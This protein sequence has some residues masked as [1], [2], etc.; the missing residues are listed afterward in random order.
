M[1]NIALNSL[2]SQRRSLARPA[3]AAAAVLALVG[4]GL[5]QVGWGEVLDARGSAS[6]P[7]AGMLLF[8][9]SCYLVVSGWFYL[10]GALW[11][12][13][14]GQPWWPRRLGLF[15]DGMLSGVVLAI[16]IRGHQSGVLGL[17]L[18]TIPPVLFAFCGVS[19]MLT[20][21]TWH[22]RSDEREGMA[23][24]VPYVRFGAAVLLLVNLMIVE[25]GGWSRSTF[26]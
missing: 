1:D 4:V 26:H 12:K 15:C 3:H 11:A 7:S 16:M 18:W 20:F 2:V 22:K 10:L 5:V 24:L 8:L 13:Y 9:T 21:L 19:G 17:G 6:R 23:T 25:L 14:I